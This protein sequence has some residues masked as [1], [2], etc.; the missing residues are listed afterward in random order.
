MFRTTVSSSSG[1][2][3]GLPPT[4]GLMITGSLAFTISTSAASPITVP[5][6]TQLEQPVMLDSTT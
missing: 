5:A 2:N 1:L 3:S 4:D 6:L